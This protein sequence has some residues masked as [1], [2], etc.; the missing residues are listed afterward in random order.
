MEEPEELAEALITP[1]LRPEQFP[2]LSYYITR[3]LDPKSLEPH[4]VPSVLSGKCYSCENES[5]SCL[6]R[7]IS[8]GYLLLISN[9]LCYVVPTTYFIANIFRTKKFHAGT[10]ATEKENPTQS[11]TSESCTES[12]T[13]EPDWKYEKLWTYNC[14]MFHMLRLRQIYNDYAK[15]FTK[16]APKC[17]L[18]MSRLCLWQLWR[19]C[20]VHKKGLSLVEIDDHIGKH[21]S[22]LSILRVRDF[23][24]FNNF[25]N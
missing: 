15:L 14:L 17:N 8:I 4:R 20:G 11:Q 6:A 7:P 23:F 10:I 9:C 13:Q 25:N 5:C 22:T 12:N 21:L 16:S 3:L 24:N 18:A 1:I 2:N 19:D